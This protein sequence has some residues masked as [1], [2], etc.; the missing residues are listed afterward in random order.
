M[1]EI[2]KRFN[3]GLP[4]YVDAN[5]GQPLVNDGLIN[6]VEPTTPNPEN[7]AEFLVELT[8]TGKVQLD[9]LNSQQV[10][11][12]EPSISPLPANQVPAPQFQEQQPLAVEITQGVTTAPGSNNTVPQNLPGIE[13]AGRDNVIDATQ[14]AG[15]V[16]G[17]AGVDSVGVDTDGDAVPD[18]QIDV[19]IP[20][21]A[22]R[23][24]KSQI[25]NSQYPIDALGAPDLTNPEQPKYSSFFVAGVKGENNDPLSKLSTLC[26]NENKKWLKEKEP[27]EMVN[28]TSRKLRKK[29]DASGKEVNDLDAN[30]KKQYDTVNEQVPATYAERK[31][32]ARRTEEGDP[33]GVGV[34]VFRII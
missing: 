33:A 25:T 30:G 20:L 29:T 1:S 13:P 5:V 26:N 7:P 16:D 11:A 14:F 27:R 8:P 23:N 12:S 24:V 2:L 3:T 32:V 22:S 19:G 4:V 34:R 31:Y 18:I 6:I 28:K 10:A 15:T 17:N 9:I 21:P